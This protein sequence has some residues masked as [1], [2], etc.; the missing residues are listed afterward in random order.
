MLFALL[1]AACP[2]PSVVVRAPATTCLPTPPPQTPEWQ[3]AGPEAGCPSPFIACFKAE[4][5]IALWRTLLELR[6][7]GREA[8]QLCGP[9]PAP[10]NKK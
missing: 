8:Y 4:D 3:I 6:D 7:Y 10:E 1:C 5:A 2:P 9:P